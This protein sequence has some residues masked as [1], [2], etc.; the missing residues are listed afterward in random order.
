MSEV[1]FCHGFWIGIDELMVFSYGQEMLTGLLE[2]LNKLRKRLKRLRRGTRC[3]LRMF[4]RF[5][6]I[7][8]FIC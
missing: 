5:R 3:K 1:K 8:E 2:S 4:I 6:S 7:Y